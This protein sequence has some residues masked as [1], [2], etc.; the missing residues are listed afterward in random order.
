[1]NCR[2]GILATILILITL[3][4][5]RKEEEAYQ[6]HPVIIPPPTDATGKD[7]ALSVQALLNKDSFKALGR[8]LQPDSIIKLS[9]LNLSNDSFLEI[10]LGADTPG[11]YKMGRSI[12][13]HTAVYYP[14]LQSKNNQK[15]YTSRATDSA[16]GYVKIVE[17]DTVNYRIKGAFQLLLLSRTD[18]ARYSFEN[19]NFDILYNFSKM[20]VDGTGL[21]AR[22]LSTS[23]LSGGNNTAPEPF[24][25]IDFEDSMQVVIRIVYSGIGTYTLESGSIQTVQLIDLKTSK[26]YKSV[27]GN[28]NLLRFNYGQFM[29]A[30][31]NCELQASDGSKKTI[32][33]GV[34]LVGNIF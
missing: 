20:N 26:V 33:N 4:S 19:G 22:S 16:G 21:T 27:S 12:S 32:S 18:T 11:L 5:C 23:G 30:T 17:I 1:M 28:L 15:G 6:Y 14:D 8:A 29:Q 7:T 13:S 25:A 3:F 34:F 31:F 2:T 24:V 9:F 10:V